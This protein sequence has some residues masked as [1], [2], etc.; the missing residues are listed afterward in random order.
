MGTIDFCGAI[1]IKWQKTSKEKNAD[2]NTEAQCEWTLNVPM[3]KV[4]E[5]VPLVRACHHA[6]CNLFQIQL[7]KIRSSETEVRWVHEEDVDECSNCR[8]SFTVTKRKVRY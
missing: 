2:V 1:H 6:L 3:L 8:V 4:N 7:E 5:L